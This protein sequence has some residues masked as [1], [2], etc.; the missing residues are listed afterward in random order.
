[1]NRPRQI[2]RCSITALHMMQ[3]VVLLICTT[4]PSM[5]PMPGMY[6]KPI[7]RILGLPVWK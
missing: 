5:K 6:L 2:A 4:V 7:G 3:L 1:M